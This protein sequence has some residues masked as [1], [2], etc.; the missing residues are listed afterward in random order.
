MFFKTD[1]S[2]SV[3]NKRAIVGDTAE[4]GEKCKVKEKGKIYEGIVLSHGK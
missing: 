1:D 2:V 4:V 3:V